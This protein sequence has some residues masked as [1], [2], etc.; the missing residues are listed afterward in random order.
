MCFIGFG[1]DMLYRHLFMY[2][3]K[4]IF[5]IPGSS[6]NRYSVERGV[7]DTGCV[8]GTFVIIGLN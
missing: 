5:N 1:K 8:C 2:Y 4:H 6:L 7:C 3:I